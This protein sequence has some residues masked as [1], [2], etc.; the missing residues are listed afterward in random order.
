MKTYGCC[1]LRLCVYFMVYIRITC[2]ISNYFVIALHYVK[3]DSNARDNYIVIV[4]AN[5]NTLLCYDQWACDIHVILIM[6]GI[7]NIDVNE[8]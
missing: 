2:M 4:I 8:N 5:T 3:M 6:V 7:Y 1:I